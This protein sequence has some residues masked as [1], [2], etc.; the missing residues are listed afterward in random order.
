S[1]PP[2]KPPV[3][4]KDIDV[5]FSNEEWALLTEEQRALYDDVTLE[6]FQNVSTLGEDWPVFFSPPCFP[7]KSGT[8]LF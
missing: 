5:K 3:P 4:F 7:G 1:L 6:N 8:M 2:P